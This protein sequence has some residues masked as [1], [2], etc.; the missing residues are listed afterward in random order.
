MDNNNDESNAPIILPVKIDPPKI[1]VNEGLHPFLPK[2]PC[3]IVVVASYRSGKTNAIFNLLFNKTLMRGRYDQIKLISPTAR[4]DPIFDK[5]LDLPEL[6]IIDE[7]SDEW[8][9]AHMDFTMETPVDDR[10]NTFMIAD[11]CIQYLKPRGKGSLL[12]SFASRFR[13]YSGKRGG[14]LLYSVQHWKSL[15]PIIR[16]NMGYGIFMKFGN[17]KVINEIAEELDGFL[18]GNFLTLYNYCITDQDYSF[19][20][21]DMKQSPPICYLRFEKPIYAGKWL[22]PEPKT[23]NMKN[24]SIT[25]PKKRSNNKSE[26]DINNSDSE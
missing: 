23:I 13:H 20:A 6:E 26:L 2:Q 19:L 1:D 14:Y 21:I 3:C 18:G 7:Y 8:L 16:C 5:V 24:F 22:I 4:S 15:P 25:E 11:D 17:A 10:P 9:K 12:A